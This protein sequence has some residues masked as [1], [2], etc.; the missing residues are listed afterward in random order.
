MDR[1]GHERDRKRHAIGAALAAALLA[2]TA[3]GC[4][5]VNPGTG[6][7]AA[8]S[9][10]AVGTETAGASASAAVTTSPTAG[11]TTASSASAAPSTAASTAGGGTGAGGTTQCS[12]ADLEA[13][14][15]IV[16]G[17][18][19]A[20]SEL[21]NVRL[22][23]NSGHTCTVYGYPGFQLEDV[24]QNALPT[25]V[26]WVSG[27]KQTIT[28]NNGG[29]AATTVRFDFD[30]P[31]VGDSTSGQCQPDAYYIQVTAP[32]QTTQLVAQIGGGPVTVCQSGELQVVPFIAGSTG[33]NQ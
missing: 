5:A 28:V 23:N 16:P 12:T 32:D 15:S 22:Q 21:M 29:S 24:H 33:P 18:Q 17:S 19:G 30:V 13:F 20:G 3:A 2:G 26:D 1:A 4:A 31:G 11:P 6:I 8:G 9:P 7:G 27:T 10:G 14:V 25:K